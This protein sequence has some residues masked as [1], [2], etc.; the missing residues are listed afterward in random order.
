MTHIPRWDAHRYNA[1]VFVAVVFALGVLLGCVLAA[2]ML[3]TR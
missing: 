3:V 2:A 1:A